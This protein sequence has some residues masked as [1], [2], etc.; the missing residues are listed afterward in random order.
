MKSNDVI[1]IWTI[2]WFNIII[3]DPN[4]KLL[5]IFPFNSF[6]CS[7]IFPNNSF[8]CSFIFPNNSFSC[9]LIFLF[10]LSSHSF[11][12]SSFIFPYFCLSI[13]SFISSLIFLYV[14]L[15]VIKHIISSKQRKMIYNKMKK[16]IPPIFLIELKVSKLAIFIDWGKTALK[17]SSSCRS[18]ISS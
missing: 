10:C 5:V 13:N 18:A 12:S 15:Q 2:S 1:E 6:S 9:S 14:C 17:P 11:N 3:S 8:S 7:F 16:Y 4:I